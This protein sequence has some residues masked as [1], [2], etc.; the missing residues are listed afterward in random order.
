MLKREDFTRERIDILIAEAQKH[1]PVEILSHEERDANHRAFMDN[2]KTEGEGMWVFGYGS[3][4][5][6]PAFHYL[7]S[8]PARLFGYRRKFCLRM[9]MGRG[10]PEKPG[11]MLALDAGGSCNGLAFY[12]APEAVESE[13]A[14][15]WR[16]EMFSGAYR[17]CWSRLQLE[18]KAVHG[19]SFVVNRD[20][21]RYI[22]HL[23]EQETLT[24]LA[25]GVGH[26][27]SSR[28][29]L[30]NTVNHL[31]EINVRDIY[32]HRLRDNLSKD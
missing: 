4:L 6:N 3:L 5:W 29:Y 28:E 7:L 17:P 8:E 10:T 16:R 25:Q 11:L 31:D 19:I 9:T 12:I 2:H 30:E 22:P 14:I 13:T 26:L 23:E 1:G 21:D 15:L 27:G 32:L 24:M 18:S 20:H